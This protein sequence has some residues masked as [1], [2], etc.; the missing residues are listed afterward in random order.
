MIGRSIY[1]VYAALVENLILVVCSL[2]SPPDHEIQLDRQAAEPP[3]VC[4]KSDPLLYNQLI[5]CVTISMLSFLIV[6]QYSHISN[7]S[8]TPCLAFVRFGRPTPTVSCRTVVC[9]KTISAIDINDP[10]HSTPP[11]DK[12]LL[13]ITFWFFDW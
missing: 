5:C 13:T 12:P 11:Y 4:I 1:E 6:L 8:P 7:F 9:D 10:Y 3:M 2:Y